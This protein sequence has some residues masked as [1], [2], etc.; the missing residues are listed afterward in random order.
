MQEDNIALKM[1]RPDLDHLPSYE[2][3]GPFSIR[4]YLP[5]DE[6]AWQQIHIEAD[7]YMTFPDSR[8]VEQF[9]I[10]EGHI[11]DNQFYLCDASGFPVGTATAWHHREEGRAH[12]DGPGTL[13]GHRSAPPGQGTVQAAAGCSMPPAA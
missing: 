7:A 11:R 10:D 4:R 5:G 2:T 12:D 3:P 13:G 1:V 8:F 6:Q 9:G